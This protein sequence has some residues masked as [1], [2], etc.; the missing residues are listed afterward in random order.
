MTQYKS[1]NQSKKILEFHKVITATIGCCHIVWSTL[2]TLVR[3]HRIPLPPPNDDQFYTV[4]YF[5][6][7]EEISLYSRTFKITVK[8]WNV[9]HLVNKGSSQ[10]C[11]KFTQNFLGKLG[12]RVPSVEEFPEDPFNTYRSQVSW[13]YVTGTIFNKLV[14]LSFCSNLLQC[15]L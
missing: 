15:S 2:G 5:N 8:L 12:V 4:E 7:G 6:V 14:I 10:G 3:R 11:D 1:L 13:K 9:M